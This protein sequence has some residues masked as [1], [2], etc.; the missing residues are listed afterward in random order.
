[1]E[2]REQEITRLLEAFNN[3]RKNKDWQTVQEL[4]Y[5][6][7]VKNLEIQLLSESLSHKMDTNKLYKLQGGWELAQTN[8][9]DRVV[10]MLETE[11]KAI[12][13]QL[14]ESA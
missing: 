14:N 9:V 2:E 12:K 3:L 4:L 10:E 5:K 7:Q 8:D 1:M 11:L 13:Q 6:R